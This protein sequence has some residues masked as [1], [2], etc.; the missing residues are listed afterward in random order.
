[1]DRDDPNSE[2][3]DLVNQDLPEVLPESYSHEGE[4]VNRPS[5]DLA[6]PI[7]VNSLEFKGYVQVWDT[8]TGDRSLQPRWLLWQTMTKKRED[9]SLVF[10]LTD[11]QIAP[12]YG[13]DLKCP[14]H[15]SSPEYARLMNM[16]FKECQ[17]GHIPN[18]AALASHL[19]HSHKSTFAYLEQSK[20]EQI[21]AE[22]RQ[23]Q[24]DMLEAM[25]K[26]A[27]RGVAASVAE[28]LNLQ[29]GDRDLAAVTVPSRRNL[30]DAACPDCSKTFQG[31]SKKQAQQRVGLHQRA[32]PNKP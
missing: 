19:S 2:W 8:R 10:T 30:F 20:A 27:V 16:G 24:R 5:E 29:E 21:R 15:P 4:I 26:A 28:P 31:K 6:A 9:G 13:A 17:K 14:L 32:C 18:Q 7:R 3:A 25:T 11:P 23:L 12:K 22:D 1:M